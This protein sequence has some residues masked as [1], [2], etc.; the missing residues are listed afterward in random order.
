MIIVLKREATEEIAQDIL[1]RIEEK[2]LQ[3]LYMPGS[4][5]VVL[6]ALGDERVMGFR[7]DHCSIT[8]FEPRDGGLILIEKG[9]E[10]ATQ[11]L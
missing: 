2:G 9:R 1:G 11:V 3:P 8:V 4:E 6:G 5:R 10:P 7:P